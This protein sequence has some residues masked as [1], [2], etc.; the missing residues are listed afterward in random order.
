M[1][2]LEISGGKLIFHWK[3]HCVIFFKS[4]FKSVIALLIFCTIANNEVSFPD[5]FVL[6]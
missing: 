2:R 6:H 5:S 4:L 3:A 1:S